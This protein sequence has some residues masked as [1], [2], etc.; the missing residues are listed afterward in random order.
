MANY[1]ELR[2]YLEAGLLDRAALALRHSRAK[3]LDSKERYLRSL[4]GARLSLKQGIV[5]MADQLD[6]AKAPDSFLKAEA[7]FV[8][9]LAAMSQSQFVEAENEFAQ[10]ATLYSFEGLVRRELLAEYNRLSARMNKEPDSTPDA[11]TQVELRALVIRAKKED[12]KRLAGV[13]YRQL[14]LILQD[15]NRLSAALAEAKKAIQELECEDALSDYQLALA[16]A[17]DVALDLGQRAQ[18]QEWVE[19]ILEA[20]DARV[21]FPLAYLQARLSDERSQELGHLDQHPDLSQAS[22]V[23]R[24]KFLKLQ[25]NFQSNSQL[26]LRHLSLKDA[27]KSRSWATWSVWSNQLKSAEGEIFTLKAKSHEVRLLE[28]LLTNGACTKYLICESLWPELMDTLSLDNRFYRLVSRLNKRISG[29]IEFDGQRYKTQG[30]KRQ[31]MS[32]S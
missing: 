22:P 4:I 28:L 13:I 6:P 9:G 11:Q 7:Y 10:A 25:L 2:S 27:H 26:E 12:F 29:L 19:Y 30:L 31:T 32:G 23:W 21:R 17:A 5:P 20:C 3:S 1:A 14:S 24:Q 8:G 15:Q 18:A 16:Q